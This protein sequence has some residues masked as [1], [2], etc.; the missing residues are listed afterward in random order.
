MAKKISKAAQQ[1]RRD[2]DN[3]KRRYRRQADRYEA[4]AAKISS[5]LN[6]AGIGAF[7]SEVAEASAKS[8]AAFLEAAQALR[9]RANSLNG[10]DIRKRFSKDTL[11]LIKD[12]KNYLVSR[13]RTDFQRGET[14]GKLRLSGSTLGHRFF[15]L[16]ESLWAGVPYTGAGDDRR[17]NAVRRAMES[18]VAKDPKLV[19]KY[20]TKLNANQMIELLG[21][22]VGM[23]ID[24]SDPY[25]VGDSKDVEYMRGIRDV[26]TNY[27]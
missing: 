1:R 3:A 24:T 19:E 27:G 21:E 14:L 13:N 9:E 6:N 11:E 7:T 12:S 23:D 2:I 26:V 25:T 5:E 10:I 16:T 20:G 17:L 18:Y 15:A 4:D 22:T 8:R